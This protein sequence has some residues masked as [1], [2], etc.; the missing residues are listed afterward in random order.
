MKKIK[1]FKSGFYEKLKLLLVLL[2]V[3]ITSLTTQVE[4]FNSLKLRSDY[5]TGGWSNLSDAFTYGGDGYKY[6]DV[7]HTGSDSYWRIHSDYYNTDYE[8]YDNNYVLGSVGYVVRKGSSNCFKTTGNAGI[9]RI[10]TKQ[11]DNGASDEYPAVWIERP[12]VQFKHNWNGGGSDDWTEVSA[13][14]N[15]DG[16]YTYNGTYGGTAYFNAKSVNGAYKVAKTSTTVTGSPATGDRCQFKWTP[17][18]Y[19]LTGD[20][21]TNRGVFVITKLCQVTYNGNSKTSGTVPSTQSDVLYGNSITLASK[22]DLARTNYVFT[23]WNTEADGTGDHYDAGQTISAEAATLAL[24]AEWQYQYGLYGTGD[25]FDEDWDT[26]VGF[27]NTGTNTYGKS[28]TLTNGEAYVFKVVDR[29]GSGTWWG[30]QSGKNTNLVINRASSGTA[31]QL[32]SA[33]NEK[34]NITITPDVTGPYTFSYNSSNNKLTITYPT[35]YTITFGIGDLNG[36]NS[37]IT[38]SATPSFSSGDYVLRTTAVTFNKGT[39]K[40]GYQF[41]GWYPNSDGSGVAWSTTDA[42]WTSDANT[43]SAN[44]KVYACYSYKTYSIT[45]KDEGNVTFSGTHGDGY[46]T[47]H[48][49]NTGTDLVD[50]T[51][52]GYDFDGWYTT[53]TCDDDPITSI[54]A[55]AY[56]D[57]ITLYAKWT[58]EEY[59]VTLDAEGGDGGTEEVTATYDAAMPS[60]TMP[61]RDHYNFDGY[62]A[63]AGGSGTKYYNANGSSA[64]AWDVADDATLHANWTEITHTVSFANDG[65]GTTSPSSDYSAG[66]VTGV[67]IS[68]TPNE[69]Y[70]FVTWTSD[71]GGTFASA[72]TVASNTFYPAGDATLTAS[73][74]ED[75]Y[76]DGVLD[77]VNGTTDGTYSVTFNDTKIVVGDVPVKAGFEVVA[78]YGSYDNEKDEY[79]VRVAEPDGTLNSNK[80]GFTDANG[81]WTC[82]SAPKLYTKWT[83]KLYTITLDRNG[84]TT[85]STSFTVHAGNSD[86]SSITFP[87]RTGYTFTGYYTSGGT[88]IFDED[89]VL[90][91]NVTGYTDS[92]SH[93]TCTDDDLELQAHWTANP[94]TI[95]LNNQ[96]A[97]TAGSTSISVT[98]DA[99]TYL[100]SEPAIT[101]PEKTGYTFGG[102]YTAVAGGGVQ[103]I[104]ANGNVNAQ[105]GGDDTYTSSTKQWK[106]AD[107]IDLY[108]KWTQTIEFDQ[109]SATVEGTDELAATYNGA[110]STGGITNPKK[111]GYAFAGWATAASEGSV[112]IEPDGTVKDVEDWTED[113]KWV[114]AGESELVATW[115]EDI[116]T[117]TGAAGGTDAFDWDNAA[118]WEGG[119]LPTDYSEVHLNYGVII[120]EGESYHVGKIVIGESRTLTLFCGGVL[121]V[122]GTITKEGGTAT[123]PTSISLSSTSAYQSALIFDNTAGNTQASVSLATSAR[124]NPEHPEYSFQYVA[125]PMTSVDVSNTFNG[126]GIYTYVWNEGDGW[127]RRGYYSSISGFEALG[128]TSKDGVYFGTSGTLVSTANI[129]NRPLRYTSGDGVGMNMIGNS[130]TAPIKISEMEITGNAESTVYVYNSSTGLWDGNPTAVSGDKIVPAMQAYLIKANSGGGYLSIDYDKAVRGVAASD[131]TAPLYAPR[132]SNSAG[133]AE[134]RMRVS[135]SEDYYSDLRLFENEQFTNEFDNG[136]EARYIAGEGFTGQLYAQA[137]DKMTVLATP[138]LEGQVVGF[139]PGMATNYTISFEGDGEGYYLND[140]DE[141]ESTLIE[142]GN[143][144]LFTPNENTNATRFVI[145]K[146]PIHKTTTGNDAINDGTKARKQ[147]IDGILYIIRDGRMYDATGALVK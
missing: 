136:W 76:T 134:I 63:S 126:Q 39:T 70:K 125:V 117:F 17:S 18:G 64:H 29:S 10:V 36:S 118:N 62:Y 11:Y 41:D 98:F 8:P 59:T 84:G 53:S 85:G 61:S 23:G 123:D 55:T 32:Y 75:T 65:N 93:W 122:A 7:Y 88:M 81:K 45:Y 82:T 107:D 56:T 44:I 95:T 114:H 138:N 58:A 46:P 146:M 52:T 112:V 21:E 108:A 145:S 49:Y 13:T 57:N 33:T 24:Y 97:T 127:E 2:G 15:N 72:A 101:V 35:S 124:Y 26:W 139:V 69:G 144:Y 140:L 106:Y 120:K 89:G 80:T 48:T 91:G 90:Q 42:N 110:L 37:S 78:Y 31:Q 30:N 43:R 121:E 128:V 131:R 60:A 142:E 40:A 94:Y 1:I 137:D 51:K 109:N 105:A 113:G 9:I 66:E 74:T 34:E 47:T 77:K 5:Y 38:A 87:T 103:V 28:I 129:V 102:Y 22:G 96:S 135:D 73:F 6:W 132:R 67:A 16:T 4:A 50:P 79:E 147:M 86:Y 25:I 141:Q 119:K 3:L 99:T 71:N 104:A 111:I 92:Y 143:T 20:E 14:D 133:I 116:C 115:D 27:P 54:G 68:A 130:W 100:T 83:P 12:G 19:K